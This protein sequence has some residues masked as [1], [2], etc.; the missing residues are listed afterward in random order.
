MHVSVDDSHNGSYLA[1]TRSA[2][3]RKKKKGR[4]ESLTQKAYK[5]H[6]QMKH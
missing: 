3:L 6:R 5:E 4:E 1:P 2:L